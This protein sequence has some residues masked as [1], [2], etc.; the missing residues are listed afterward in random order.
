MWTSGPEEFVFRTYISLVLHDLC[1]TEESSNSDSFHQKLYRDHLRAIDIDSVIYWELQLPDINDRDESFDSLY[2]IANKVLHNNLRLGSQ[3]WSPSNSE[4]VAE[5][6]RV[7]SSL[8][9]NK[10]EVK[11]LF[12]PPFTEWRVGCYRRRMFGL[13]YSLG[14]A[15]LTSGTL[16]FSFH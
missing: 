13:S 7:R 6:W 4:Q 11:I 15:I 16:P 14:F 1:Y 5:E 2:Y 3:I 9:I 12:P 10:S 8:F